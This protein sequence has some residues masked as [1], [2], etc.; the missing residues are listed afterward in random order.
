MQ[1]DWIAGFI[2]FDPPYNIQLKKTVTLMGSSFPVYSFMIEE[3]ERNPF[4]RV[5][6]EIDLKKIMVFIPP[7]K[8]I[9][10]K[11]VK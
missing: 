3:W 6:R 4:F 1:T 10:Q 7:G 9:D 8:Q 5:C 11:K 2:L